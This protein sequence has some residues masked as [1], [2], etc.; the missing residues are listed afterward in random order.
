MDS[1]ITPIFSL[2]D[3]V[4]LNAALLITWSHAFELIVFS[5]FFGMEVC[6]NEASDQVLLSMWG[7]AVS[8]LYRVTSEPP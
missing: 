6:M 2:G 8:V 4:H 5:V 3:C 7:G 1:P